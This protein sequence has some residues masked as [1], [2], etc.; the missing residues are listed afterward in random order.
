MKFRIRD[1][2]GVLFIIGGGLLILETLNIFSGDIENIIWLIIF[3]GLGGYF[4]SR[5]L[6]N[7][8]K[9]GWV[10]PGVSL[11]GIAIG[12]LVE[13]I[14]GAGGLYSES[15]ILSGIGISF[16]LVYFNDRI[17]WWALIPGGLLIS[18]GVGEVIRTIEP[19]WVD[20]GGILFLGLG[21]TFLVLYLLPT[22]YGRLKWA[23][24]PSIILLALGSVL[25]FS[26][27]VGI[28]GFIGS[29]F[30]IIAG[31]VVLINAIKK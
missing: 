24:I 8:K 9:W 27:N 14:S 4:L 18:L 13:L 2:I 26:E 22:P 7:R 30:I 17:N 12:N 5:Y 20:S 31:I 23:L 28:V 1:T 29:G 6:F 3:G 15:I 10:I 16:T 11:I 25:A 21:I 19:A